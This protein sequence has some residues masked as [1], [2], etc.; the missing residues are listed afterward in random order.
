[1]PR[2]PLTL[3]LLLVACSSEE[4]A[5]GGPG[6][7]VEDTGLSDEEWY[8]LSIKDRCFADVGDS[9]AGFPV[10]DPYDP[11]VPRHCMGT[12]HQDIDDIELLVFLG[13]SI[14]AGSPPNAADEIY[15]HLL[16]EAFEER[17]PGLEVRDC[18]AWGARTD[19]YLY[20]K[21]Q[22]QECFPEGGDDKRT[23][24]IMTM[25]GNDL[26]EIAQDV[27]EGTSNEQAAVEI[28]QVLDYQEE[29]LVWLT[30]TSRFPAGSS[31]VSAN[32]YE[33]TDATGDLA[34]CELATQLG[35][36]FEI[37]ELREA[38]VWVSE[39]YMQMAVET[40]TDMIFLLE[41]FCGHG[42]YAGD[43]DNECY[44]G[45]DAEIWFDATCIHPNPT[46]HAQI[47]EMFLTVVE[48]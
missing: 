30:D 2:C 19:D 23:L 29:A 36:G 34:S 18:S 32:V 27:A 4:P 26:F 41:H 9:Q 45:D 21:A 14:T 17:W 12:D 42:F 48:H 46:G 47:A 7:E 31:V 13:D 44:R 24:V 10:Y 25:G 39:A 35:F 1:M 3:A 11:E 15:R 40:N 20:G 6:D 43:P 38:Y 16:T 5:T 33:F 8:A 22:I 28:Q 37:P